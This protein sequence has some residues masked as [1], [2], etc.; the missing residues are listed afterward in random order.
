MKD[1]ILFMGA[2]ISSALSFIEGLIPILQVSL[3]AISLILT[4]SGLFNTILEKI[5]RKEDISEDLSNGITD[6]KEI[7][8]K[9]NDKI[10]EIK[11]GDKDDNE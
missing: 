9:I 10:N 11:R 5:K 3:L 7:S 6:I 2:T 1:N 8:G 4:I